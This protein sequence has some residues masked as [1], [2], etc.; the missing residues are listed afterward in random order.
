MDKK[1]LQLLAEKF[2]SIESAASEIINLSAIRSLPKGTECFFSD[3]HGESEAFLHMLKSASGMIKSKIDLMLGKAVSSSK[4][5]ELAN[6]IYYPER[7]LKRL[8]GDGRLDEEWK[9]LT[10]YRLI[11]VCEAVSA[12]YTRSRVRK[13]IPRELCYIVDEL[14]NVAEDVNKDYYYEKIIGSIIETDIAETFIVSL[15][16]LIQALAIDKLHIIGDIFDRGP[17]PDVILDELMN[18]H[19]VD[20]QWG[21]H[22]ISWIGAAAGNETLIA[23]VI[24]ISIKY[25][26]FDLLEDGYGLNMRALAVF[27]R[28][29]YGDDKCALYYPHTYDDNIYDPIDGELAAQMHKAISVIQLKLES[30]LIQAHPEWRMQ[31]RDLFTRVDFASGTVEIGQKTYALRDTAFPTVDPL[32]PAELSSSEKELM[33]ILSNSFLHSEKLQRHIKF[34]LSK[35]SMYKVCNGNLMF[36]GCI[37]M[38]E[39]GM[40]KCLEIQGRDYCGKALLDEINELVNRAY[41]SREGYARDLMWYLWCG[42]CS[43]LFGKD[44]LA[45][46]EQYFVNDRELHRENYNQYYTFSKDPD[47]C[48]MILRHFSMDEEKGHIINGHVPVKIKDGESPVKAGGKLFVIDGGISKAYQKATGIAG[49]TLIYDSHGLSLAEHKPFVSGGPGQTPEVQIVEKLQGR[50]NISDTDKGADLAEQI[51][52]LRELLQA[53]RSGLIKE[54]G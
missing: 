10:I 14:L 47:I 1:Y 7:E 31:D 13:R 23:N 3:L 48:R 28:E 9:R 26:N 45:F 43:P 21:N 41:F 30:R 12:K 5:E 36:H 20:I 34:L 38:D 40:F 16:K 2:P 50:A 29:I 49:Y 54:N 15:C 46:F 18:M 4:R 24:R 8:R 44:K 39:K 17:R 25:N 33:A 42:P 19:D 51:R 52:D 22:D 11:L 6:L 37:P 35:G 53:Y 27:A 32:H